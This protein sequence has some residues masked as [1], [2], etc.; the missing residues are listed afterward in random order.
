MIKLISSVTSI[1]AIIKHCVISKQITLKTQ[2]NYSQQKDFLYLT[3]RQIRMIFVDDDKSRLFS[4]SGP[5]CQWWI[6]RKHLLVWTKLQCLV[7]SS[8]KVKFTVVR[9]IST[10]LPLYIHSKTNTHTI[11]NSRTYLCQQCS[12]QTFFSL[13]SLFCCSKLI[14]SCYYSCPELRQGFRANPTPCTPIQRN[15]NQ[16]S[17]IL[18]A[19]Q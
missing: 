6:K 8:N 19:P 15:T 5:F 2:V 12:S 18:T 3:N 7:L 1:T 9:P 4:Q 10:K 17:L 13:Y 14:L 16:I 11:F